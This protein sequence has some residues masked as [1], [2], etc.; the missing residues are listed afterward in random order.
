MNLN[1]AIDISKL[2]DV[3]LADGG[4][5]PKPATVTFYNKAPCS[6]QEQNVVSLFGRTKQHGVKVY[7]SIS[8]NFER[9]AESL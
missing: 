9:S 1:V 7:V 2:V 5:S 6:V 3:S 8:A 4:F